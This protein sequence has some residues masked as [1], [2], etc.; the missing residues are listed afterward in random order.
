[1]SDY[2][3]D[4]EEYNDTFKDQTA[5]KTTGKAAKG[6]KESSYDN[7]FARDKTLGIKPRDHKPFGVKGPKAPF[8]VKKQA[9]KGLSKHGGIHSSTPNLSKDAKGTKKGLLAETNGKTHKKLH[10]FG[11]TKKAQQALKPSKGTMVEQ[12]E[13][14]MEEAQTKMEEFIKQQESQGETG[15]KLEAAKQENK[16][17]QDT[18]VAMNSAVNQLF[19]K[20][21]NIKHYP[22]TGRIKSPPKSAQMRYRTKEVENSQ[23]ALENIMAEHE[24]LSQRMETVKDPS[25]YSSLHSDLSSVKQQM[26][27]AEKES[28]E[29]HTEQKRRELETEKLLAQG[30]PDSMFQIKEL[31]NKVTINKDQLLEEEKQSAELDDLLQNIEEREQEL[32]EKEEKLRAE[33]SSLGINFDTTVDEAKREMNAQ[34]QNKRDTYEKHLGIAEHASK[35]MKKKL[36]NMSKS[37]KAKLRELEKQKEEFD[38]ELQAKTDQVKEKNA[39]IAELMKKNQ[40]LQKAKKKDHNKFMENGK[41]SNGYD[42]VERAIQEQNEKE[43]QAAILIQ[44]WGRILLAKIYVKRLR[45]A[46]DQNSADKEDE[47]DFYSQGDITMQKNPKT[48]KKVSKLKD[49]PSIP[50]KK[51]D[52]VPIFKKKKSFEKPVD[53]G[54]PHVSSGEEDKRK[55]LKKVISKPQI[56]K[57]R[58]TSKPF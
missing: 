14:L 28:K 4:F 5:K 6:K 34:L 53:L 42:A 58:I 32:K 52:E 19:E 38:K 37:N 20:Q 50:V 54:T 41:N 25:Y 29:L 27:E 7:T 12:L 15:A 21:M 18:M 3:D 44:K 1:M 45:E 33:G 51:D 55:N 46:R 47:D 2:D 11:L 56:G 24:H 26:K 23:K 13:K 36:K 8:T 43:T 16:Y 9:P 49:T 22:Q 39:E 30:A 48:P 57:K 35:V 40:E 31:Q 17:L 10:N